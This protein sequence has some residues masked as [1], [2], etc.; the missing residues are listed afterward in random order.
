MS[1]ELSCPLHWYHNVGTGGGGGWG[2]VVWVGS[3]LDRLPLGFGPLTPAD[4]SFPPLPRPPFFRL[5]PRPKFIYLPRPAHLTPAPTFLYQNPPIRAPNPLVRT[6]LSSPT[7][8]NAMAFQ[9]T[10]V[11]FV[12]PIVCSDAVQRIHWSTLRVTSLCKGN[13]WIPLTKG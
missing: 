13:W 8:M 12:Y 5:H 2:G 3:G 11:L 4:F 9:I 1:K 10:G 7:I 6:P